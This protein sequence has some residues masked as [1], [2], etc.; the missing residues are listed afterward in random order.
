ME[1]KPLILSLIKDDLINSKLVNGL[2]E[3]GL[4]ASKYFIH[5]S[6]T[7]FKLMEFQNH[8]FEEELF[9]HYLVLSAKVKDLDI[10]ESHAALDALS[11]EIYDE[12]DLKIQDYKAL[13]CWTLDIRIYI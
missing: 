7:A 5:S 10:S 1:T 12:L 9:E 8:P 6:N 2:N 13:D 3:L 4:D 11:L